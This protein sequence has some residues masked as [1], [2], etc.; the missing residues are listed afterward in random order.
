MALDSITADLDGNGLRIGLVQARFNDWAGKALADACLAQLRELGVDEDDITHITV[1]GALEVP[2]ALAKLARAD[3]FDA[4]IAIG[5]VIRG[6]TYHFE[7]VANE[8]ARGV[9]QVALDYGIPVANAI[10]TT[11]DDDQA[12]ARVEEKGRDAA[13]VAVEM[14][15]LMWALD[16]DGE[17]D[18][19]E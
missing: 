13:K 16:E 8:S 9:A 10:L 11:N 17:D 7:I 2:L 14:A 15:N 3:D 5:C 6:E 4:L 18:S 1:P 12:R 19:D